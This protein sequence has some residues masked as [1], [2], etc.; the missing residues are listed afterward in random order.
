MLKYL[1]NKIKKETIKEREKYSL[2]E[3]GVLQYSIQ[4]A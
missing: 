1:K 2:F 3:V 4:H